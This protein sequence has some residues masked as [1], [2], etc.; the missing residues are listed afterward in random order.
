M[1]KIEMMICYYGANQAE[2][3]GIVYCQFIPETKQF[4]IVSKIE[5]AGKVNFGIWNQQQL[6]VPSTYQEK[7]QINI[8]KFKAHHYHFVDCFDTSY[9]YSY[10][11]LVNQDYGYFASFSSGENAIIDLKSRIEL[12]V[13]HSKNGRSHYIN[14][15]KNGQIVAIDNSK[16]RLSFYQDHHHHLT[17]KQTTQYD[18]DGPRLMAIHPNGK[19]GY[20]LMESSNQIAVINLATYAEIQRVIVPN[21]TINIDYCGGIAV[22]YLGKTLCVT[23]RHQNKIILFSIDENGLLI[24]E[25]SHSTG[26]M[27]RDLFSEQQY[28]FVTCTDANLIEVF[29][30]VNLKFKKV[31]AVLKLKQPVTF[32]NKVN[33][34]ES[35]C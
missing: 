5:I 1:T 11:A 22:D 24:F 28:Y 21:A 18:N 19:I 6:V 8:L 30:V 33:L 9:F 14:F 29:E 20:L 3:S 35:K 15:L 10:G 31:D 26:E 4:T 27:P 23:V 32:I 13:I 17:L 25:D 7:N 12:D 2:H 16:N 34:E